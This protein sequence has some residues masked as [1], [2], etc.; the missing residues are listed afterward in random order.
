MKILVACDSFKGS[1]TANQVVQSI[2]RGLSKTLPS[3]E[4]IQFPMSDGGEGFVENIVHHSKG[5]T[6]S[7]IVS[8]PLGKPITAN[9]GLIENNK[10]AVIEIAEVIGLPLIAPID[11]NPYITT[12]YGVGELIS[13]TITRDIHRIILAMGGSSTNDCGTGM[14]ESLGARFVGCA[15]PMSGKELLN[16][17]SVDLSNIDIGIHSIQI[18]ALFDVTNPLLGETGASYIFGPQKGATQKQ[19]ET[20]ECGIKH[21][22][23][24]FPDHNSDFEG[25]G[26]AGGMGWGASVFLDATIHSGIEFYLDFVKFN[27]QLKNADL[28]ITG[29]GSFDSQSLEGK[30]V[31]GVRNRAMMQNIP[32]IVIAGNDSNKPNLNTIPGILESYSVCRHFNITPEKSIENAE[33][34]LVILAKEIAFDLV[35]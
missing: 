4:I 5:K 24:L 8:G 25:A 3:A 11:R 9:W 7:D 13:K 31:S 21:L 20:L 32:V 10:T 26:A 33:E 22:S 15:S 30:V 16:I 34:L 35:K 17:K 14:A 29:E 12:S 6:I 1:L 23:A 19:V 28:V 2:G 27:H 18:D